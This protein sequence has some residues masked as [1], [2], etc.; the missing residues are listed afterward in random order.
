[1]TCVDKIMW[2]RSSHIM[3][4][5]K[6]DYQSTQ[7]KLTIKKFFSFLFF[8]FSCVFSGSKQQNRARISKDRENRDLGFDGLVEIIGQEVMEEVIECEGARLM[9]GQSNVVV[10]PAG[11]LLHDPL[12][13]RH[14]ATFL[15]LNL[16]QKAAE[17]GGPHVGPSTGIFR[18]NKLNIWRRLHSADLELPAEA[19]KHLVIVGFHL[20]KIV[21]GNCVWEM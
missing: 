11:N 5:L 9:L 19:L 7:L 2:Q 10:P 8:S 17:L 6:P 1:M 21:N 16:R 12:G 20:I 4:Y 3:V 15:A 14:R 18:K 13:V